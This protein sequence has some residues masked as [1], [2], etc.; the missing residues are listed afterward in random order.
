[1]SELLTNLG[2]VAAACWHMVTV[3]TPLVV[4]LAGLTVLWVRVWGRGC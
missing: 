3:W 1:M 2:I 4:V